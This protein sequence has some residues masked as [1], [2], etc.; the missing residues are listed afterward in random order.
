MSVH[1]EGRVLAASGVVFATV[2]LKRGRLV[3]LMFSAH[4]V[5]EPSIYKDFEKGIKRI[6]GSDPSLF[7]GSDAEIK[8]VVAKSIRTLCFKQLGKKPHVEVHI[9]GQ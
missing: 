2:C 8:Q 4:G 7:A 5:G 9:L 3:D 6:L 1:Q